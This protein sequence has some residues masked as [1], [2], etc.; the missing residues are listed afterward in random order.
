[1]LEAIPGL[2]NAIRMIHSISRYY[3]TQLENNSKPFISDAGYHALYYNSFSL[4]QSFGD[5][6]CNILFS[7]IIFNLMK[8]VSTW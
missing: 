8:A 5:F 3:N 2:I 1:M 4:A 6:E 7:E